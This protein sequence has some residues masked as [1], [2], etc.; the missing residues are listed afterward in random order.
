M[1][2]AEARGCKMTNRRMWANNMTI[3][4]YNE[5]EFTLTKTAKSITEYIKKANHDSHRSI[6]YESEEALFCRSLVSRMTSL[7]KQSKALFRFQVEQALFQAEVNH[8]P[9]LQAEMQ[10]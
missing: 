9:L 10:H 2:S 3:I 5:M 6:T 8:Q 4:T 1:I 7:P